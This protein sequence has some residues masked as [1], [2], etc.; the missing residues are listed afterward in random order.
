MRI[1]CSSGLGASA[2]A[3][4]A[5]LM[6]FAAFPEWNPFIVKA[7]KQRR[8]VSIH[9]DV[10]TERLLG[11]DLKIIHSQAP[12]CFRARLHFGPPIFTGGRYSLE[13]APAG[14]TTRLSH[15]LQLAGVSQDLAER[16]GERL[17]LMDRV[18]AQRLGVAIERR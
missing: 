3:V 9:A 11:L 14:E 13:I 2:E 15:Q 1:T 7:E 17:R 12:R 6:D 5:T 8:L 18:L 4:W 16:C 10:G